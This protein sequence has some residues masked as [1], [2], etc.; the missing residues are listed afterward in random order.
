MTVAIKN[1]I[2]IVGRER[3]TPA[4]EVAKKFTSTTPSRPALNHLALK[5]NGEMH[6]TDTFRA[7]I[8]KNVHSY[9]EEILLNHKTL[10]LI[11][12]YVFPHL[13]ELLKV[14]EHTQSSFQLSKEDAL[15]L[16]PAIK[17][18]KSN[19][20]QIMKFTFTND[21]IELSVPGI[22]LKLDDF[23]FDI[24]Q[25]KDT[26]NIISFT[27]IYLLDAL[28]AFLKFSSNENITVHHQGA[29]KVMIFENEDMTKGVLPRRIY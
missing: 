26:E 21:Y 2:E 27:P 24:K 4:L 22:H 28:E 25:H 1:E 23:E 6:A 13:N 3:L 29:L 10:D 7:I 17:F 19:K 5:E 20:F 11:K 9:Q 15:K 14:E 12:G 18:I 16:I 8:L